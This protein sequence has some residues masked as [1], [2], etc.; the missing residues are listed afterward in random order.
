MRGR[1]WRAEQAGEMDGSAAG[2]RRAHAE[3]QEKQQRGT[4]KGQQTRAR[5]IDAERGG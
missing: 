5:S 4:E 2:E 3:Q 1:R